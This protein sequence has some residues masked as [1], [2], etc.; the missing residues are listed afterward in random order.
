MSKLIPLRIRG[1][2]L[3][4]VVLALIVPS[5]ASFALVGPQLGLGVGALTAACLVGVAARARYDEPIEVAV[6]PDERFRLLVVAPE[7]IEDPEIVDRIVEIAAGPGAVG[8][9]GE[10]ELRL[11]APARMS[12]LDRWATDLR[13]ARNTAQ[14][15]LAV[16]LG[17][18][19]A[20]GLDASGHLGDPE[21]VQAIADELGGFAAGEVVLVEGAGLGAEQVAEIRRRL[22]RPVTVLRPS[23]QPADP[24]VRRSEP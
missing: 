20:A 16:S 12:T 15:V 5:V 23:P 11:L 9:P 13:G 22:D 4:L 10:A 19:A 21:P 14:R 2:A 3:P 24:R 1:W 6:P 8:A 18:L 17:T 7:P